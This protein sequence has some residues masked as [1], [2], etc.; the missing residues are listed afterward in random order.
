MLRIIKIGGSAVTAKNEPFKARDDVINRLGQELKPAYPHMILTHGAGS[1]GHPIVVKQKLHIEIK[2]FEKILGISYTKY[3]VNELMQKIMKSLIDTGIPVFP[4]FASSF[5]ILENDR[6]KDMFIEP[7]KRFLS[8]KI[9]PLLPPDG[10]FDIAKN[11]PRIVSG[12]YLAYLLAKYFN[13]KEVIFT[14]DVDGLYNEG[15]LL[16][17]VSKDD[18]HNLINKISTETDATGGMRGKLYWVL[19]ILEE[20]IPVTFINLTIPNR[21]RRYL[22]GEDVTCT[23]FVP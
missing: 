7:I 13:A 20:N 1:F 3:W 8:F 17:E 4:F 14:L 9:V 11:M 12:D 19:K 15:K 2:G 22:S 16:E 18:L 10:S 6:I 5:A 23:R 21:L